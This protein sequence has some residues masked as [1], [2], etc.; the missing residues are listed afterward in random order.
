MLS[1][2]FVCLLALSAKASEAA[3][4]LRF[5][6]IE[7]EQAGLAL[8]DV[9]I[10]ATTP[11]KEFY[12]AEQNFRFTFNETAVNAFNADFPS[13]SIEQELALSG[14]VAQSFYAPHHLNGSAGN[15]I[16]Y[17]VELLGGEGYHINSDEWTKVGR[18][19]FQLKSPTA[20]LSLT[21]LTTDNF[22]PTHIVEKK[23]DDLIHI[24][25]G[26]F[27][28]FTAMIV[29]V[30]N[31]YHTKDAIHVFP[32]PATSNALVNLTIDATK[33]YGTGNILIADALGRTLN[34]QA[35]S[36]EK[37]VQTYQLDVQALSAGTYHVNVQ[38]ATW[39]ST[40]KPLVVIE[41]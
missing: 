6:Q 24:Y 28:D 36:I 16:S 30:E 29:D 7:S 23:A 11:G 38:T 41:K 35:I 20:R 34:S 2:V 25:E 17:N 18:L 21:W 14:Q 1:V 9:E 22:P 40:S 5:V 15:V 19:A 12:L 10:R 37:G 3:Y 26:N 13:V 8:I 4:D 32:N 27:E 31:P 39:Q 33:A